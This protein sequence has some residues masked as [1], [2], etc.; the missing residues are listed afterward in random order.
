M[1]KIKATALSAL[2]GTGI[3]F[4]MATQ[5]VNAATPYSIVDIKNFK[6]TVEGSKQFPVIRINR[7]T[8]KDKDIPHE[9][10]ILNPNGSTAGVQVFSQIPQL[11]NQNFP[12]E[13]EDA[14]HSMDTGG[15]KTEGPYDPQ[16]YELKAKGKDYG[17]AGFALNLSDMNKTIYNRFRAGHRGSNI[18]IPEKFYKNNPDVK[19]QIKYP[20]GATVEV[21][22]K[23]K[24]GQVRLEQENIDVIFTLSEFVYVKH[25]SREGLPGI[26]ISSSNSSIS[27]YR[28]SNVEGYT[29]GIKFVDKSG[30]TVNGEDIM[31]ESGNPTG[32][33]GRTYFTF[34]SLNYYVA[35]GESICMIDPPSGTK[36]YLSSGTNMGVSSLKS[37]TQDPNF[38]NSRTITGMKWNS[39]YEGKEIFTPKSN[40][41]KD[42]LGATDAHKN[43]VTFSCTT[44]NEYKFRLA[45]NSLLPINEHFTDIW[46]RKAI[47]KS[48]KANNGW[49][50]VS[51]A[52]MFDIPEVPH[53]SPI[54]RAPRKTVSDNDESDVIE[55]WNT[56]AKSGSKKLTYK[57]EQR[58]GSLLGSNSSYYDKFEIRDTLPKD[59]NFVKATLLDE[60]GN[61]FSTN[62]TYDRNSNT[63]SWKAG[64]N[65]L[66]YTET[67]MIPNAQGVNKP[68]LVSV[69]GTMP[70]NGEKY[71]LAIEVEMKDDATPMFENTGTVIINNKTLTSN[72]VK[73]HSKDAP[74]VKVEKTVTTPEGTNKEETKPGVNSDQSRDTIIGEDN[75]YSVYAS[76]PEDIKN[77]TEYN[78]VDEL[79]K[80]LTLKAGSVKVDVIDD[81]GQ[82]SPYSEFKTEFDK[83]SNKLKVVTLD[84]AKLKDKKK[85]KVS[86]VATLN[87]NTV[88]GQQIPNEAKVQYKNINE[89]I[90]GEVKSNKVFVYS[91]RAEDP[92]ISK[93][94]M[95][96]PEKYYAEKAGNPFE[97]H[98]ESKL[99]DNAYKYEQFIISDTIDKRIDLLK[100]KENYKIKVE[101]IGKDGAVSEYTGFTSEFNDATREL[102]I[103]FNDFKN[104]ENKA[105]V[106]VT[107]GATVNDTVKTDEK[108]PNK[109]KVIY[110]SPGNILKTRESNEV[111]VWINPSDEPM[112]EKKVDQKT[113]VNK[114]IGREFEY[115][116]PVTLPS[117]IETYK[118]FEIEDK[119]DERIDYIP[120]SASVFVDGEQV[121]WLHPTYEK[122]KDKDPN[123]ERVVSLRAE[124]PLDKLKGKKKLTLKFKT[125]LNSKARFNKDIPNVA[126]LTFKNATM[127]SEKKK[128]TDPT[129][130]TPS[131]DKRDIEIKKTINGDKEELT[132]KKNI[133]FEY[134]LKVDLPDAIDEYKSFVVT[135]TLDSRIDFVAFESVNVDGLKIISN[136]DKSNLDRDILYDKNNPITYDKATRT[137][138]F[139][140]PKDKIKNMK[141]AKAITVNFKAMANVED[142]Q[143]PNK[144]SLEITDTY[145]K[146]EKI[147]SNVVK[148]NSTNGPE[149]PNGFKLDKTVNGK[150]EAGV[151][152]GETFKY[153][154]DTKL[155]ERINDYRS[156]VI[157]DEL[158]NRLTFANEEVNITSGDKTLSKDDYVATIKDNKLKIEFKNIKNLDKN[159]KVVFNAKLAKEIGKDEKVPNVYKIN[160]VSPDGSKVEPKSSNEVRV[161]DN[162]VSTPTPQNEF[163]LNKTVNDKQEA[164]VK[165]GD[166]FTYALTTKL[167]DNI[168]DYKQFVV[169]DTLDDRIT[170][171]DRKVK[172]TTN[173]KDVSPDDYTA[174]IK[175]QVI[176]VEFK[177][178]SNL[179]SNVRVS[180]DSKLTKDLSKD[181]K[182]P[183]IFYVEG[184][185][186][187]G[188]TIA[189]KS[190]N[191]VRLLNPDST[192]TVITPNAA[193]TRTPQ[194]N[195]LNGNQTTPSQRTVNQ[196]EPI[197]GESVKTGD[198]AS[199]SIVAASLIA[200]AT[201]IGAVFHLRRKRNNY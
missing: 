66:G 18:F 20:N 136:K 118:F 107:L 199:K 186:P 58:V 41:F 95:G 54:L 13:L 57:I 109:A 137:V 132:V 138:K 113:Q 98:I 76:I 29:L 16:E 130:V 104:F 94:I 37:A 108:I 139:E 201:A 149:D 195:T 99:P 64:K 151:A 143:I 135:D 22:K 131:E 124:E 74:L 179:E 168:K 100:D 2:M 115:E 62:T 53:E 46:G 133:P 93:D 84:R 170:F 60:S 38:D 160:A 162:K 91:E 180:F 182:V 147:D 15:F 116:I 197:K 6:N 28:P 14:A 119:L 47:N 141:G 51:T 27:G 68:T 106:K 198:T 73:T 144:A 31:D 176:R 134:N 146:N 83:N 78:V 35:R 121:S 40:D 145:N 185:D 26:G 72:T 191:E 43:A 69:P 150:S 184:V 152:K 196:A 173:G 10:K 110:K 122:N 87:D 45:I 90:T 111:K 70:M 1:K 79:N 172:V 67:R 82:T 167:P 21:A 25:E 71:T 123:K 190:S 159:I 9:V 126:D 86:F 112:I 34:G 101:A 129:I 32:I 161:F 174:E 165:K 140:I 148:V 19:I 163:T 200:T 12:E 17:G 189:T 175:G 92:N 75:V 7:G 42:T 153:Y 89:S 114:V 88:P 44:A 142:V 23:D 49:Q 4:P 157:E 8:W 80:Q 103:K 50:Y 39:K 156:L 102:Q 33:K 36:A 85:L 48:E 5:V 30:N 128:S 187:N 56:P 194:S 77:Y 55:N 171:A 169:K 11:F 192:P 105:K 81:A 164:S 24:N 154:L 193:N 177:K 3:V 181:E 178:V 183:N 96:N 166:V 120:N 59:V 125:K 63:V 188:F 97:Y 158:D 52:P 65:E 127:N 117:N 61:V 155:P